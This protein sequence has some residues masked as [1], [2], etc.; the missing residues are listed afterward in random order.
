[1][2]GMNIFTVSRRA[3]SAPSRILIQGK[4]HETPVQLFRVGGSKV[5]LRDWAIEQK[6]GSVLFDVKLGDDGLVHPT[7]GAVYPGPN[8]L[9][10]RP[11][12]PNLFEILANYDDPDKKL[13]VIPRGVKLPSELELVHEHGDSYSLQ[14]THPVPL[15]DFNKTLQAFLKPF[16]TISAADYFKLY[17]IDT[18]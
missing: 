11:A 7:V 17:P 6:K 8:G 4:F 13:V 3:L 9:S 12:G 14:T 10:L 15:A 18:Q 16:T 1:M 5:F 2:K